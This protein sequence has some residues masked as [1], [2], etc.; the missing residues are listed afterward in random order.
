MYLNAT[1]MLNLLIYHPCYNINF[2]LFNVPK[3]R[4]EW[5]KF[6]FYWCFPTN[7]AHAL[8]L[9]LVFMSRTHFKQSV[10]EL[11]D[12][13]ISTS[14]SSVPVEPKSNSE[15]R[16]VW[17]KK[18]AS[19]LVAPPQESSSL[20]KLRHLINELHKEKSGSKDLKHQTLTERASL[21]D[22]YLHLPR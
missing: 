2:I 19:P 9:Y 3:V 10:G 18:V 8:D 1:F 5:I 4:E 14:E 16:W 17:Q 13:L 20:S 22:M 15:P 6:W 11:D 7:R 12:S 21:G